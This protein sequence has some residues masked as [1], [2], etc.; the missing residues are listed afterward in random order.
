MSDKEIVYD[1]RLEEK[2]QEVLD[3]IWLN[4]EL[5]IM[6]KQFHSAILENLLKTVGY[7]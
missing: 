7:N 3:E 4:E 2:L 1:I 6:P 5:Q